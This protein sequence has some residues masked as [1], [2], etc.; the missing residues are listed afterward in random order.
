[1][2]LMPGHIEFATSIKSAQEPECG[3]E[4]AMLLGR[5]VYIL[6]PLLINFHISTR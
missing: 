4:T 1:M 3:H 6:G 5:A 2:R